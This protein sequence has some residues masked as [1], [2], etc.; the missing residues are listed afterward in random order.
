M[1]SCTNDPVGERFARGLWQ[2]WW[3]DFVGRSQVCT[4]SGRRRCCRAKRPHWARTPAVLH[5]MADV[6]HTSHAACI[7]VSQRS[8]GMLHVSCSPPIAGQWPRMVPAAIVPQRQ[9]RAKDVGR[10]LGMG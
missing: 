1:V 8:S 10:T 3:P 6:R 9:Q 4:A 7:C 2:Q 5:E